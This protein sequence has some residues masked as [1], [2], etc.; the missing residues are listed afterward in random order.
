MVEEIAESAGKNEEA[1]SKDVSEA[2]AVLQKLS[3]DNKTEKSSDD[4]AGDS[5]EKEGEKPEASKS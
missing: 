1:E 5:S 3:V 2:A 4:V